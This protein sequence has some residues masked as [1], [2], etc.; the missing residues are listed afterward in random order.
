MIPMRVLRGN[1][2]HAGSPERSFSSTE[3]EKC[4]QEAKSHLKEKKASDTLRC[5]NNLG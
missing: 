4:G 2:D 5:T 1:S 3:E